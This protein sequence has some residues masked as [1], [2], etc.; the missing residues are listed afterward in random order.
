MT[1]EALRR[2]PA[3]RASGEEAAVLPIG[4]HDAG[5]F[6]CPSCSRPLAVGTSRCPGC[7]TRLVA[8]VRATMAVAFVMVG[9]VAG[10]LVGAGGTAAIMALSAVGTDAGVP[11]APAVVTPSVAPADPPV[12]SA[13]APTAAVDPGIPSAVASVLRQTA[14]LN[15]RLATESGALVAAL[16]VPE[17]SAVDIARALRALAATAAFGD[18]LAAE[19]AAWDDGATV[20]AG[21]VEFYAAVGATAREGL[22]ASVTNT[23]AYV[24]AGAAMLSV[25]ARLRALDADT[26]ALAATAGIELPALVLPDGVAPKAPN[27]P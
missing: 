16:A 5:I 19:V 21:L 9:G 18:R 24:D 2:K 23:R 22:D 25:I 6:D 20:A 4:E 12:A 15:Q 1:V 17:P 13:P 11:E 3:R 8:G 27:A 14:L 10:L 26:R 7:R